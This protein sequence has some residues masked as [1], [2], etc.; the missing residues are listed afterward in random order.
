M[1]LHNPQVVWGERPANRRA[2]GRGFTL[3]ELLVVIAIIAILAAMLLPTLNRSKKASLNAACKSNLRQLGIALAMYTDEFNG[4]P[5]A[6]DW[7]TKR[8]WYDQ[9]GPQYGGNRSLLVCP[10]FQ[11]DRNVDKA[12]VWLADN[13]F[14]YAPP[15]D[16][17]RQ[18]GVSYGYNGYGLRSTGY[19]YLD[20]RE[21]L[22]LGPSQGVDQNFAPVRPSRVVASANMIAMGDS[23]LMPLTKAETYSY[24]MALGDGTRP[25]PDRHSAGSNV[26]FADGHAENLLNQRLVGDN[27]VSR[28]RWN[29][30]NDPHFEIKLPKI[31]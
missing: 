2:S 7:A 4:Y 14:Y 15:K 6:L 19:T 22:G 25:S 23:M 26:A 21:V 8:F 18:N 28:R 10:A 17:R 12:P 9:I 24:L 29:N 13:F 31:D 11:G 3:I 1:R 5:F 16:G 20:D 27:F 30:D